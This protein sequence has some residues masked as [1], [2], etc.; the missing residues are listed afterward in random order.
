MQDE[1][2]E[3]FSAVVMIAISFVNLPGN[4]STKVLLAYVNHLPKPLCQAGYSKY[5]VTCV[6]EP[7]VLLSTFQYRS[8]DRCKRGSAQ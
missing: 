5:M 7:Q 4:L 1:R 8:G 2:H 6:N 3:L